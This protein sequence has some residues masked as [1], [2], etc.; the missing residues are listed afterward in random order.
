MTDAFLTILEQHGPWVGVAVFM[1]WSQRKDYRGVCQRLNDVEDYCKTTLT[2]LTE[3]T[4]K[5]LQHNSEI[6]ANC[7]TKNK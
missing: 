1:I 6:I 4:T 5:A 2:K 3:D 7:Q